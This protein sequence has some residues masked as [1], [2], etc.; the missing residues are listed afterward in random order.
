MNSVRRHRHKAFTLVELLVVIAIIGILVALL[1]PAIQA[2]RESARRMQCSNKL[3]QMGLAMHTYHDTF[4]TMPPAWVTASPPVLS[5]VPGNVD[6]WPLWSWGSLILP[7][8]EQTALQKQLSVGNPF[9]VEQ[10]RLRSFLG[11]TTTS[12]GNP[13]NVNPLQTDM[14]MLRCPSSV[15]GKKYLNDHWAR[16]IGQGPAQVPNLQEHYTTI[17]SYVVSSSTYVTWADGGIPVEQGAFVEDIGNSFA[18][19]ADGTSNII[20]AGERTWQINTE[21]NVVTGVGPRILFP[22]GAG[23]AFAIARRNNPDSRTSVVAIGRPKMNLV[24]Y[25]SRG[26]ASRGYSSNHPGGAM[27][28]FCDASVHF[29]PDTID[30][31]HD[32]DQI[33]TYATLLIRETEVDTTWERLISRQDGANVVYVP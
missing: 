18:M 26:W 12:T 14:P 25:N 31:D 7:Y 2:A 10:T 1:L 27:F 24:D 5:G 15:L 13:R 23:N 28:L 30:S 3:K 4:K 17:S 8:L 9:H 19:L 16:R 32:V 29:L 11:A 22:I 33:T 20:A 21:P 6:N